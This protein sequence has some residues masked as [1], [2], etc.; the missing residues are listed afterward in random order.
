MGSNCVEAILSKNI[1]FIIQR[2]PPPTEIN[3]PDLISATSLRNPAM[4]LASRGLPYQK[5]RHRVS[6]P[7]T[8]EMTRKRNDSF[9]PFE[10]GSQEFLVPGY[11]P[12]LCG[13]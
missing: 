10:T 8:H 1:N 2:V 3:P 13:Q 12:L 6:C 7:R 4:A 5:T 9:D 11:I